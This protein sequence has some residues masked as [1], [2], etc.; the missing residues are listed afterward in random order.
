[1]QTD[2][3]LPACGILSWRRNYKYMWNRNTKER[4]FLSRKYPA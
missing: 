4:D 1:M 2:L 3:D